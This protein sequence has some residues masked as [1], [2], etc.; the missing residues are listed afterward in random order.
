[1]NDGPRTARER[2]RLSALDAVLLAPLAAPFFLLPLGLLVWGVARLATDYVAAV[3][4]PAAA[5]AWWRWPWGWPGPRVVEALHT[6]FGAHPVSDLA[7]SGPWPWR[8]AA[9][10]EIA[11][12]ALMALCVDGLVALLPLVLA[13][14][15]TAAVLAVVAAQART[16]ARWSA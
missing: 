10:F 12:R 16:K 4:A 8:L 9:S 14:W 13:L 2:T 7:F 5:V 11:G 15:A 6:G 1:M 3:R